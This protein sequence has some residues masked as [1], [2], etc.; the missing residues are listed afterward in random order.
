MKRVILLAIISLNMFSASAQLVV[1]HSGK[2]KEITVYG[3]KLGIVVLSNGRYIFDYTNE[4][5]GGTDFRSIKFKNKADA[6]SFVSEIGKAFALGDGE[7]NTIKY[8]NYEISLS[9]SLSNSSNVYMIVKEKD[10]TPSVLDI[11][12]EMYNQ[13]NIIK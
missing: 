11:T 13:V 1:T 3:A 10:M 8:S 6:K 5:K 7:H 2:S 9:I 12:K 4:L